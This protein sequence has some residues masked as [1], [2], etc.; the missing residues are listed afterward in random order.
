VLD[1]GAAT[2]ISRLSASKDWPMTFDS[3]SVICARLPTVS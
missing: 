1:S 3:G 2:W